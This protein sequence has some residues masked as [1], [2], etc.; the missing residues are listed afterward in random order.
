MTKKNILWFL[1]LLLVPLILFNGRNLK[2]T[3]SRN[4]KFFLKNE[5]VLLADSGKVLFTTYCMSCHQVDGSGV[6]GMYPPLQKSDWVGGDKNKLILLL[7]NGL[8]GEIT[9]NGVTYS[10]SMPKQ[11]FLSN[12]QIAILLTY[13]RNNFGNKS[14]EVKIT[15][16]SALRKKPEK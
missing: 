11:D 10:N 15:D 2:V 6:P 7:L 14:S 12:K 1:F 3:L 13:I 8:E 4:N 5:N 9:V 16:V